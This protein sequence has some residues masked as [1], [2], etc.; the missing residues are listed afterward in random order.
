MKLPT[1]TAI[2]L[3]TLSLAAHGAPQTP[4]DRKSVV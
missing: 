1:L 4:P 2:L 3:L